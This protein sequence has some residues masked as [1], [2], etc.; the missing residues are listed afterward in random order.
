M[1]FIPYDD[2]LEVINNLHK[3]NSNDYTVIRLT[4]TMLNKSIIDANGFL[5]TL[6]LD[7]DLL[8]FR[9][10]TDKVYLTAN[11]VLDNQKHRVKISFYKA[12]KR[13]DE[14]FWI[15]GLGKFIKSSQINVNDLIYITVNNQKELTLFNVTHSIPQNSTIIELFGQDKVED[16]LNRLIPQIKAIARQGFHNNSKGAGKIA[17]KDAGDTLES[18]LGIQTNNS[19]EADFEGIIELKSKSSKTLDTLFTLRPNFEGTPV[20]EF[21]PNDRSRVSAFARLY[22]YDSDKHLGYKSLYITI[23]SE[24]NP[25]NNQGF[26]LEVNDSDNIVELRKQE[27]KKSILTAFWTFEALEEE[28]HKKHPATLWVKVESKMDGEV[29][30]FKYVEAELTRSPQFMTFL[31]L[32]KS[33][34]ITYDWR[35]YTT[36]AGKYVGKNH[37]NAWRIK[38]K[39][40]GLLFGSTEVIDLSF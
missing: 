8:D 20:A 36:P 22:G 9:N 21:E 37:G 27:N 2:E 10:L 28:L 18:L 23:G 34:A 26:Y 39:Q 4:Q 29:G 30:Q 19:Q 7:N 25:Q 35:G 14:R 32:I 6:L 15:Y 11:L 17:P 3:Y 38:N 24:E 12:N 16:S 31:S 1:Q 33:G 5:R 40:R 13:G